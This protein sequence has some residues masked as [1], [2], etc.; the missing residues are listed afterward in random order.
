MKLKKTKTS[1]GFSRVEFTDTYGTECTIQKSS[2][3]EKDAIW[4]GVEKLI[5]Q[6][7]NGA[8]KLELDMY[9]TDGHFVKY[10][11]PEGSISNQHM[12]LTQSQVKKLL[13]ILAKFVKT[14]NID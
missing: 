1:R 12:H 10:K 2:L 3:A 5:I 6:K 13:P 14:G 7:M 11:L 9:E 8:Q 4:I